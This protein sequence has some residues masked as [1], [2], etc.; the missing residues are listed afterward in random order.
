MHH[1]RRLAFTLIELLVVIAIIAVLIGLLLPAVQKVREAAARMKCQNN[2]KQ[3]ALAMHNYHSGNGQF[4]IGGQGLPCPGVTGSTVRT[5]FMPFLLQYFEQD[6]V[7]KLY[8]MNQAFN[9]AAN[10]TAIGIKLKVFQCPSDDERPQ[11]VGSGGAADY[12]GNYGLNWGRWNYCDQGGPTAN[13]APLNV[14]TAGRAPFYERYGARM[15]HISDGTSNTLMWL[16]M[17]QGIGETAPLDRRG[18]LWNPDSCGYNV[19]TRFP[20]NSSTPDYTL[21]N[22]NPERGLPCTLGAGDNLNYYMGSRSRH[23]GGVNVAMCDGSVRFVRNA[24]DSAT[25]AGASSMAGGE[26]LGDL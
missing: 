5:P 3:L 7:Y 21:C 14:G 10:A 8:D 20:P 9:A 25:W 11:F 12:K 2:V 18:R 16:E 24:V 15:E 1:S 26:V 19:S 6:N 4:P 17:L 13:A 22:N 23:T